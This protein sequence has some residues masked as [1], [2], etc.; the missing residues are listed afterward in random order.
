MASDGMGNKNFQQSL[1]NKHYTTSP[2]SNARGIEIFGT[3]LKIVLEQLNPD[4]LALSK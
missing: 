2:T 1:H 3:L 4:L